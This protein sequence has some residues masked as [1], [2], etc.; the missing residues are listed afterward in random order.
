MQGHGDMTQETVGYVE[1]EWTC[2]QCGR[3]NP[4][5]RKTCA[6]CGAAMPADAAFEA[7]AQQ[8]LITDK[9]KLARAVLGPD[10]ACG[11]CGTRNPADAKTCKQ[12]GADLTQGK[13][14][15]S[16]Q[17]VGALRTAPVPD[18]AC[19]FCGAMNPVTATKCKQCN[20]N[21]AAAPPPAVAPAAQPVNSRWIWLAVAAVIGL[22][23]LGAI[24][25]SATGSRRTETVATVQSVQWQRTIAILG[26]RP[27]TAS[28]WQDQ[29]PDGADIN[30]CE[31]R[32]R[33]TQDEPAANAEKVCG[34]PY[35]VD[36]GSGFGKVVQDCKYNV[37]EK[38]CEYQ[39][40]QWTVINTVVAEGADLS[41]A[42]PQAQLT[43]G[44]RAGQ[45]GEKYVVVFNNDGQQITYTPA[46]AD[47]FAQFTPGSRWSLTVNGFGSITDIQLA[48]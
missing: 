3:R 6:S 15:S 25:F 42:W 45:R 17:V 31:D 43:Q 48:P 7:P 40:L 36:Q 9:G 1:L 21:L 18:A 28:A 44:E 23:L 29:V 2:R 47:D 10:I 38:W 4:G 26:L 32:V 37:Y 22:C 12:C 24:L 46:S 27:S 11:F 30:T 39:T 41:P 16:G 19:P 33:Y 13:A 14:R 20:G 5:E 35:V 8:E 34:T